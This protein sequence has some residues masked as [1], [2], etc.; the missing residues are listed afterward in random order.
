MAV[1]LF[2]TLDG[3]KGESQKDGHKED[4]DI[5][6]FSFGVQQVGSFHTGGAGGGAGKGEFQDLHIVK[7]IDKSTPTLFQ[8]SANGK[9]I[10][11]AKLVSRKV[12]GKQ[13]EYYIIELTDVLISAVNNAGSTG[14]DH[15]SESLTLNYAAIKFTYVPQKVDGGADGKVAMGWD[16]RQAKAIS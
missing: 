4:I 3:I 13:L 5:L 2:L 14:G 16:V 11:T 10:K 8:Y 12:G 15:I 6:S 1:D 7:N 9:Y